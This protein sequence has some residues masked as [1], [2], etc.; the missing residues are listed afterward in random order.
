MGWILYLDALSLI[1]GGISIRFDLF[2][3]TVI[4]GSVF[5]FWLELTLDRL[6]IAPFKPFFLRFVAAITLYV[7][8]F[9]AVRKATRLG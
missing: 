1:L 9:I 4:S 5:F 3:S 2:I 6:V 8:H 7:L